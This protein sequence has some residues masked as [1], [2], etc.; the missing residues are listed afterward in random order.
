LG[1]VNFNVSY[2]RSSAWYSGQQYPDVTRISNYWQPSLF[3]APNRFSFTGS[4]QLPD[5]R[6]ANRPIHYA[7]NGWEV[8]STAI[9][10]SGYPFTVYTTAPFEPVLGSTGQVTGLLPGSGDYNGDGYN[11]DFPNIPSAGYKLSSTSTSAFLNGVVSA[12]QFGVPALG[13]E[14]NELPGRFRGPGFFDIDVSLIKNNKLTERLAL[15]LRFEFF[16]VLN[17]PNLNS[18]DGNLADSTFGQSTTTFNPRW[19]QLGAKLTF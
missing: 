3:D 15:Q 16:N 10:Q 7:L 17:H 2:T 13:T 1:A 6:L 18:V 5:P 11:Y 9:V 14:G 19:L 12:S 4:W 8:S